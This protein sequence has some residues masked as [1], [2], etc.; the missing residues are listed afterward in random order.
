MQT[1]LL[2]FTGTPPAAGRVY[3]ELHGNVGGRTGVRAHRAPLRLPEPRCAAAEDCCPISA[4]GCLGSQEPA[5]LRFPGEAGGATVHL[6]AGARG[7][8]RPA[9]TIC[10]GIERDDL[11][12]GL[13]SRALGS[14][15]APASGR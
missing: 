13:G 6:T 9:A 3:D 11:R 4:N 7:A 5:G 1:G 14:T 2:D 12:L 10:R 15:D 8:S